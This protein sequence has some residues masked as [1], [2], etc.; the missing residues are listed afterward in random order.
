M[1]TPYVPHL[2]GEAAKAKL[3]SRHGWLTAGVVS[4]IAWPQ[5]DVWV[6]YDGQEYVLRGAKG[7]DNKH[8]PCISTPC[9]RGDVDAATTRV[10]LFAS[11]LGWFKGG[12]VDVTGTVWGTGPIL[13]GSR[14]T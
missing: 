10:Y 4:S 9:A 2:F 12:H 14:D 5:E 3:T 6:Q 8:P 13:Y 1:K 11:V 7:G